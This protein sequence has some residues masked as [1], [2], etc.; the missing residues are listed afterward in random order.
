[1]S[2]FQQKSSYDF[3]V[4]SYISQIQVNKYSVCFTFAAERKTDNYFDISVNTMFGHYCAATGKTTQYDVEGTTKDFTEY[5]LLEVPVT[6]TEIVSDD[7]LKLTF[8]T[9][10]ALTVFRRND[11][12]ESMTINTPKGVIVID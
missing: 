2:G 9:G 12:H 3:F 11:G 10:D 7:E 6:S 8:A 1:M 5:A 4:G